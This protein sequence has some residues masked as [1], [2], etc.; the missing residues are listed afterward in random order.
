MFSKNLIEII[1][2]MFSKIDYFVLNRISS[3]SWNC[4][5]EPQ[6]FKHFT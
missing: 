4:A 1:I 5:F 2:M 6:S 3:Q